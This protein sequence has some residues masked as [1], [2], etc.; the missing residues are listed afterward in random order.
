MFS[1]PCLKH[2][3]VFCSEWWLIRGQTQPPTS[4]LCPS[5]TRPTMGPPSPDAEPQPWSI[6]LIGHCRLFLGLRS[7]D[8]RIL[9][10][11]TKMTFRRIFQ[12]GK[13]CQ[14]ISKTWVIAVHHPKFLKINISSIPNM[15]TTNKTSFATSNQLQYTSHV[16]QTSLH[17]VD[18]CEI[19]HHLGCLKHFEPLF[20]GRNH[21]STAGFLPPP[22][23]NCDLII[24]PYEADLYLQEPQS[25]GWLWVSWICALWCPNQNLV[26]SLG[27]IIILPVY[28][29]CINKLSM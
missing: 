10:V 5:P 27:S 3:E 2:I 28:R 23:W 9:A 8:I 17:T 11:L 14:V 1:T 22:H 29:Y 16:D 15:K 18:R 25:T 26:D 6:R 12:S 21:R 7:N 19:L 20:C 24:W 13:M 4:T